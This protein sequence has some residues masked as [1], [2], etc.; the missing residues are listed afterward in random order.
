[1]AILYGNNSATTPKD[2]YI[3]NISDKFGKVGSTIYNKKTNQGYSNPQSFFQDAGVSSF[4]NLQFDTNYKPP[5]SGSSLTSVNSAPVKSSPYITYLNSLFDPSKVKQAQG[6][7][8]AINERTANEVKRARD[9][10][11]IIKENKIGQV[12]RGQNYELG[13]LNQDSSRI[14]ADLAIAKGANLDVYNQMLNAGKEGYNIETEQEKYLNSLQRENTDFNIKNKISQPYYQS[15]NQIIDA[16]TG[17]PRFINIGGEIRSLDGSQRYGSEQDFFKD[18]GINSWEQ[19]QK[20]LGGNGA[21]KFETVTLGSGKTARKVRYGYD[22]S[23][24]IVSATDLAT[25]QNY[26]GD[27]GPGLSIPSPSPSPTK[28]NPTKKDIQKIIDANYGEWGNAADAIDKKYGAGTATKFD[29]ELQ[30]A[31]AP[32]KSITKTSNSLAD[33]INAAF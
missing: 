24:N 1:M 11:D 25:G 6:N 29:A 14:L 27:S 31:Y 21:T 19:I 26:M 17:Q 16:A 28:L 3:N 5:V 8:S 12:E 32:K 4:D 23:G 10:E 2:T 20:D 15:G 22:A 33:M 7:I 30:K 9:L 18:A 13:K